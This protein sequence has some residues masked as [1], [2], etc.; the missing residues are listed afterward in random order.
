M[1]YF[2]Y[3]WCSNMLTFHLIDTK[4]NEIKGNA[5]SVWLSFV[6]PLEYWLLNKAVASRRHQMPQVWIWEV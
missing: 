2:K 5:D 3:A 1:M 4:Y 6:S